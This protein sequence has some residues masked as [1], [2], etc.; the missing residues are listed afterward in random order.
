MEVNAM[1]IQF[2]FVLWSAGGGLKPSL[3]LYCNGVPA[4]GNV[5]DV[6][7]KHTQQACSLISELA[8][9]GA[10]EL[11]IALAPGAV[12]R[13]LAYSRSVAHFPT[14]IKEARCTCNSMQPHPFIRPQNLPLMPSDYAQLLC[15]PVYLAVPMAQWMNYQC[16]IVFL[17]SRPVDWHPFS[18]NWR[19][20][21]GRVHDQE[22]VPCA[23]GCGYQTFKT[24]TIDGARL[25]VKLGWQLWT[26]KVY[27][28]KAFSLWTCKHCV[29]AW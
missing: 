18:A 1:W 28:D 11:D 17:G 3:P 16:I 29:G 15:V 20:G 7:S 14:A 27:K 26:C 10:R 4:G 2:K 24:A 21:K 23:Q 5:G 13:L 22:L 6:E 25:V 8:E 9:G 12:E 19:K